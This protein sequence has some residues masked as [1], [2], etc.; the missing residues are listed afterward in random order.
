MTR[1]DKNVNVRGLVKKCCSH[2][3]PHAKKLHNRL[4]I[5]LTE[6]NNCADE[7][8]I[9]QETAGAISGVSRGYLK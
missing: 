6:I 7:A 9:N 8:G 4:S 2:F 5:S 3:L 1:S